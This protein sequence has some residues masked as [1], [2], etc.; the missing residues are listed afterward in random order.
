MTS[1]SDIR[2]S[3]SVVILRPSNNG[4]EIL[5]LKRNASLSFAPNF[6]VFPGGK[7]EESDYLDGDGEVDAA[8][9][10]ARR[11]CEEEAA[12]SDVGE[13]FYLSTWT[14][15]V[16]AKRRFRTHLF[17]AFVE[18]DTPF[19]VDGSEIV[20]GH[21]VSLAEAVAKASKGEYLMMPPTI[22]SMMDLNDNNDPQRMMAFLDDRPYFDYAPKIFFT[23]EGMWAL[24]PGDS[25]WAC[26][27]VSL[28]EQRH[29]LLRHPDYSYTYFK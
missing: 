26:G 16:A 20:E 27:D 3:A 19:T 13:L 4:F 8:Y 5:L 11:E 6:W 28:T 15:P 21:W 14:A 24:Y 23:D 18:A 2:P 7:I 1:N 9:H 29:R 25:G 12:I 17:V 22:V 10:A